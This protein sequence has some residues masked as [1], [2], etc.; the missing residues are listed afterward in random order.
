M[1]GRPPPPQITN[2]HAT[3]V[4]VGS[5]GI[6][7]I[8]LSGTGKSDLALRLIE[9]GAQLVADDRC[10]LWQQRGQLWCRPPEGLAGKIE[11][12]GIGIVEKPFVATVPVLLAVRLTEKYERMPLDN[13][14]EWLAGMELP[15]VH[16]SAF[17]ST[18]PLKILLA[19]DRLGQP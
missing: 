16:L 9:Q 10:D 19:L 11:V 18:T 15:S 7:L 6:V 5:R 8:G 14:T 2:I 17:E 12:R 3:C 1:L 13:R 4:A